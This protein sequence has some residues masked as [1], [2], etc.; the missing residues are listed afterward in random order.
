MQREAF[1]FSFIIILSYSTFLLGDFIYLLTSK[2]QL[3]MKTTNQQ[4]L[5]IVRYVITGIGLVTIIVAIT[6][7]GI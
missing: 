2:N 6:I 5:N 7:A 4:T 3:N 1:D